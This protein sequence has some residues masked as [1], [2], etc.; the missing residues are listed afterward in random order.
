MK[1]IIKTC[2]ISLKNIL[3]VTAFTVLL[4]L[5][6][7]IWISW[8]KLRTVN[9]ALNFEAFYAQEDDSIDVLFVG[10][11]HAFINVNTGVLW[12]EYGIPSF[13]LGANNQ[14]I[15]NSYY[16]LK[17][18]LKTQSPKLVVLEILN[19]SGDFDYLEHSYNI[20]NTSGMRW[21][22]NRLE[23]MRAGV[24]DSDTLIDDI[25]NFEEYHNRYTG[26]GMADIATNNLESYS[27]VVFKGFYD[28][29]RVDPIAEPV[30]DHELESGSVMLRKEEYYYRLIME[31]CRDEDIPLMIMVAPDGTYS[32]GVRQI[33]NYAGEIADEYGVDYVD[34]NEFYHEMDLDFSTDFADIR[35]LNHLGNRKFTSFL[36]EYITGH[37][38]LPDRREEDNSVYDSWEENCLI[39]E[40]RMDA[41]RLSDTFDTASYVEELGN[42]GDDYLVILQISDISLIT[43]EARC[44]LAACGISSMRP[45]DDRIRIIEGTS[46]TELTQNEYGL[47]YEEYYDFHHLVVCADGIYYDGSPV[48]EPHDG[49]DIVVIDKHTG[50]LIDNVTLWGGSV[51]REVS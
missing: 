8:F 31:L 6:L 48:A 4:C 16:D 24:P 23:A 25:L 9:G 40:R 47:Y 51:W 50:G 13:V 18:A 42:L 45:F 15:W 1:K 11:S 10:S 41:W 43:D 28:Y 21:N 30:F 34:F 2:L 46:V 37:F 22:L 12:N 35:H 5:L 44:F 17:E 29:I 20:T 26:I 32:D 27:G 19:A 36:G 3:R 33:Y 39:A 49:V 14:P 7:N 38:D